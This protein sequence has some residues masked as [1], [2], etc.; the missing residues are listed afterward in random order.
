M[1]ALHVAAKY[2]NT[3]AI[4]KLLRLEADPNIKVLVLFPVLDHLM[5]L[6]SK[7]MNLICWVNNQIYLQFGFINPMKCNVF[8][9]VFKAN[10][11]Y[12][13]FILFCV[14]FHA[15]C[16]AILRIIVSYFFFNVT[17]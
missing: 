13:I 12:Y 5:D 3:A 4:H 8:C 15:F 7:Y 2:H 14:R 9:F 17:F 11:G 6:E 16:I 10:F 1:T